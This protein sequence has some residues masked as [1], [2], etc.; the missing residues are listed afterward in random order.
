[1][2][3]QRLSHSFRQRAVDIDGDDDGAGFGKGLGGGRADPLAGT[4]HHG[5]LVFQQH[6]LHPP[7]TITCYVVPAP[8]LL[9]IGHISAGRGKMR[10]LGDGERG[11][12]VLVLHD[13]CHD[14]LVAALEHAAVVDDELLR[15]AQAVEVAVDLRHDVT[16]HHVPAAEGVLRVRPVVHEPDDRAE[17]AADLQ[18]GLDLGDQIVRRADGGGGPVGEGRLVDRLVRRRVRLQARPLQGAQDVLVVMAQQAVARLL[19]RLLARL[20]DVP[21]QQHAPLLRGRPSCRALP[22]IPPQRPTAAAGTA[23]PGPTSSR[24]R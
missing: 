10:G 13:L 14:G 3:C 16:R 4:G 11:S 2:D 18:H 6:D 1:M 23:A 12:R 24:S 21:A 9:Q 19:S 15:L 7:R 20:G 5:H 8:S 17:A 22:P